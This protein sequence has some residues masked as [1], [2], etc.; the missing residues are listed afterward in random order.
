VE[1]TIRNNE[2][3][4]WGTIIRFS[5][6]AEKIIT[7]LNHCGYYMHHQTWHRNCVLTTQ[8]VYVFYIF[9][10]KQNSQYFPIQH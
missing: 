2:L 4:A 6:L 3:T 9:I 8:V 7:F 10:S 5:L 1:G